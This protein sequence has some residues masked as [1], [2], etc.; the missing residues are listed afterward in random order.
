MNS[1]ATLDSDELDAKYGG[2]DKVPQVYEFNA[3]N[4]DATKFHGAINASLKTIAKPAEKWVPAMKD[5]KLLTQTRELS[6]TDSRNK[7]TTAKIDVP[8]KQYNLSTNPIANRQAVAE[9][10]Y[11]NIANKDYLN[12]F[13]K[14]I[15]ASA[16]D[17]QDPIKSEAS[18]KLIDYAM[19]NYGRTSIDDL[20][21]IDLYAAKVTMDTD[22]GTVIED[23]W[24]ALSNQ[25]DIIRQRAGATKD[26]L[27]IQAMQNAIA[28]SK[29]TTSIGQ[30]NGLFTL[31]QKVSSLGLYDDNVINLLNRKAKE[32]G[33]EGTFTKQTLIDAAN[34]RLDLM[35][36][37]ITSLTKG[38]K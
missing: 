20:T 28:E 30:I 8:Q 23:D 31:F 21:G 26:Q 38:K 9:A 25:Y 1:L 32:F 24:E 34:N 6:I 4:F 35:D 29:K 13:R 5:G 2:V 15:I 27:S 14:D 22:L 12:Y 17:K 16:A 37:I 7:K 19:T 18:T 36:E 11:D 10:A 33:Y 3:K